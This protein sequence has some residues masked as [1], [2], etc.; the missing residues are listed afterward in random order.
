VHAI[1]SRRLP[2]FVVERCQRDRFRQRFLPD[3]AQQQD[4]LHHT[5]EDYANAS[6]R[7]G[8]PLPL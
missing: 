2:E 8:A 3:S 7:Q 1:L 4:V 6:V 5:L